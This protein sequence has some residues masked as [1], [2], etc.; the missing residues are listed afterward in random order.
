M[1]FVMRKLSDS[2]PETLGQQL[3]ALRRTHSVSI[4]M[5]SRRTH[6]RKSYLEALEKG[7]Y[8]LLPD[9]LYIRKFI[10]AYARE[11]G[12][13]STYFLEL[14]DEECGICDLVAPHQAPR[15][16]QS[17]LQ[18]LAVSQFRKM[19]AFFL[20]ATTMLIFLG[21]HIVRLTRAP[22]L[23]VYAP[24][25]Y[26]ETQ[27]GVLTASG[28]VSSESEVFVNDDRA[29]L[30]EDGSFSVTVP[31]HLGVNKVHIIAKRPYSKSAEDTRYVDYQPSS[32]VVNHFDH[33]TTLHVN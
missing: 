10:T 3:L 9:G 13:D 31:L 7:Q 19:G 28:R 20:I 18:F 2:A 21:V 5:L 32:T 25:P 23:I 15:Q 12:A 26:F 29:V 1:V 33:T 4:D 11:L 17:I 27:S 14:Y 24:L 22:E 8:E 30:E 16:R 6:I